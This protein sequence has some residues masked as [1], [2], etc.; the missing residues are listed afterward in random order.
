M[1]YKKKY[2][3]SLEEKYM[4]GFEKDLINFPAVII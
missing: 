4:Y 3:E 1:I 2:F